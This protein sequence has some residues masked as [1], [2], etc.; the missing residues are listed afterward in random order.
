MTTMMT[1]TNRCRQLRDDAVHIKTHSPFVAA[2]HPYYFT[3]GVCE[4]P[5]ERNG[6]NA[7]LTACGIAS[8]MRNAAA[9]IQEGELIVGHNYGLSEFL[10]NDREAAA[11]AF[12]GSGFSPEQI[13]WYF[14]HRDKRASRFIRYPD[15]EL[16]KCL[17][18]I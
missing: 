10:P 18:I 3:K 2:Q 6:D 9:L 14:A 17:K 11:E 4:A 7:Y 16:R 12:R 1:L 13:D 15:P 8:V 5:A